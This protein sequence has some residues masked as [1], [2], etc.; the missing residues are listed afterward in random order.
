MKIDEWIAVI[1]GILLPLPMKSVESLNGPVIAG[2][3]VFFS[4]NW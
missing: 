2:I 1:A 3:W 4:R